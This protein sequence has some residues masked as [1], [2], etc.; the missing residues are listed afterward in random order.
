MV[1]TSGPPDAHPS[2][3][4]I[5]PGRIDLGN[6]GRRLDAFTAAALTD[7]LHHRRQRWP[8]PETRTCY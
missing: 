8:T 4:P 6:G 2:V 3:S 7:Y 5:R 1:Q